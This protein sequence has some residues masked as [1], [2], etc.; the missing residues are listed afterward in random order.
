M[1]Q[2]PFY[3]L[4]IST[5]VSEIAFNLPMGALPLALLHD[6]ATHSEVAFAMGGGVFAQLFGSVPIGAIVDR[7]G[8]LRMVR[9]SVVLVSLATLGMAFLHGPGRR[10]NGIARLRGNQ[11]YHR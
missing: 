8:R 6:G 4:L 1:N 2:R 11:L 7:V 5:L 10:A 9:A 3:F